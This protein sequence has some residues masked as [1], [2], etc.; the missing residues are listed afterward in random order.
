MLFGKSNVEINLD[1]SN[2]GTVPAKLVIYDNEQN[3]IG[4]IFLEYEVIKT[5][6]KDV[7]EKLMDYQYLMK[8]NAFKITFQRDLT[9][10]PNFYLKFKYGNKIHK[11]DFVF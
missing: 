11:E 4:I 3:N 7:V 1:N 10:I 5:E 6:V 9:T 8:I 2:R